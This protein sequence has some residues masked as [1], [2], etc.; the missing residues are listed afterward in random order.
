MPHGVLQQEIKKQDATSDRLN[1][2]DL[3]LTQYSTVQHLIL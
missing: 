2:K 1:A 3:Y